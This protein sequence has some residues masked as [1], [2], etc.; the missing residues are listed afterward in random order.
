MKNFDK[1]D[2]AIWFGG[3]GLICLLVLGVVAMSPNPEPVY[4]IIIRGETESSYLV[5]KD[6]IDFDR[7]V[8]TP[9]L[10]PIEFDLP[11]TGVII[12]ELE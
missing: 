12:L 5:R 11:T 2:V 7:N 9:L 3:L 10:I 6:A 8:F 1:T 4:R